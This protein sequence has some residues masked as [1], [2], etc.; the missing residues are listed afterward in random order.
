[1]DASEL[2]LI[3]RSFG[4]RTVIRDRQPLR[5]H[6]DFLGV[7]NAVQFSS[8]DLDLVRVVQKLAEIG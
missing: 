1:M 6:L 7:I 8:L 2:S 3:L 5:R 4:R